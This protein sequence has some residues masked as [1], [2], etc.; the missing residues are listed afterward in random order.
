MN[1]PS[2]LQ[3]RLDEVKAWFERI[4]YCHHNARVLSDM[5]YRMSCVLNHCTR[6]MSKPYYAVDDMLSEIDQY[7]SDRCEEAVDDEMEGYETYQQRARGWGLSCFGRE[8]LDSKSGRNH[9]FAEEAIELTQAL[10]MTAADWTKLLDY[11]Y[12]RP[13]GEPEQEVGGVMLTLA[14]LCGANKMNMVLCGNTELSRV[15]RKIPE[16]RAKQASKPK[17]GPL[18]GASHG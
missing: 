10:G 18:P 16:I 5:E 4:I 15:W 9:R 2:R 17:F 1:L 3:Y 13:V 11:V 6:G 12:G 14:L 7:I 8:V